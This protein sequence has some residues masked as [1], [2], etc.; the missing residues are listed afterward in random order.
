MANRYDIDVAAWAEQ[1]ASALRRRAAN[2]IDWDNVWPRRSTA[3]PPARSGRFGQ[4]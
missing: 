1:Q 2:E 3:S 4:G